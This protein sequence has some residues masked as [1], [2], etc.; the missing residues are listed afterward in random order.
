MANTYKDNYNFYKDY[1]LNNSKEWINDAYEE[2]GYN[3]PVGRNR[4][5][6]L[7]KLLDKINLEN[8]NILDIGCGGGDISIAIAKMCEKKGINECKITAID[9]SSS[10]IDIC[11]EKIEQEKVKKDSIQ[12]RVEDLDNISNELKN[13]KFDIIIAFGLIGYLES[14]ERFFE[15]ISPLLKDNGEVIISFRNQLFDFMSISDNTLRDIESGEYLDIISEI[16]EN[17]ES[18]IDVNKSRLFVENLKYVIN[19]LDVSTFEVADEV[20]PQNATSTVQARQS[21]PKGVS[22]VA[23]CFGFNKINFYGIHPHFAIP[24]L[25]QKLS[26]Q[27]YNKLS[28]TLTVFEDEKI[29]LNWSSVIIADIKKQ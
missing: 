3:Y 21:T 1:F 22:A 9:R 27:L 19:N 17:T 10:M 12:F 24:K 25:N 2:N 5:R 4:L 15:Y 16:K 13:M 26:T 8:K 20:E 11:K 23:S 18:R 28:D 29:A 14:D 6:V 7:I